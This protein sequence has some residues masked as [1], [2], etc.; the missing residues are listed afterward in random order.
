VHRELWEWGG[1]LP[2]ERLRGVG[3]N[4]RGLIRFDSDLVHALD[5]AGPE[6][7]RAVASLAARGPVRPQA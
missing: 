3:G 2:S 6:A 7:Q 1:R 5:A 4:V